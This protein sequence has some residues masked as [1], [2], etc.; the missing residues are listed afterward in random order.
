MIYL[1]NSATTALSKGVKA[2]I[3]EALECYGNPSSLHFEGDKARRAMASARSAIMKALGAR[4]G[5]LIFTSCGSEAS[6]LA[7][8]GAVAAKKRRIANRIIT[9]DSE[10]P[11]VANTLNSLESEGF[12]IVRIP[13]KSGLLDREALLTA[14]DK[15]IF[16]ASIMLVNNETGAVYDVF[17]AFSEIK[18]KYPDAICHCDAVQGF[19][20]VRFTP[21]SLNADMITIS[22]HKVHA[23][24]G[25]GALWI[26]DRIIKEKKL[27]SVLLGGGQED[28]FRSGTE[29]TIGIIAFAKAVSEGSMTFVQDVCKMS[30]LRKYAVNKFE[31]IG[32]SVK[33]NEPT[34][35]ASHIIS[36]T[37]HNIKSQTMLNHLSAKGICVSSG[38]ACSSH[39]NK[40]SLVLLSF[41]LTEEE[42]DSTIR[43]SLSKYNTKEEIDLLVSAIEEG[44]EKLVK[45]KRL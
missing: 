38:S 2:T 13:T 23:P 27:V 41:G 9:T 17:D 40:P 12:E 3:I 42:A 21:A 20:K 33:I 26:S 44:I 36:L 24:K 45:V 14:L 32:K 11:S 39:S 4:N 30:D 37:V 35:P 18:K 31:E 25:I 43:I 34:L 8:K 29:N 28:G 19:L 7:I 1:D 22:G 6:N 10:H 5:K 16:M 15:P